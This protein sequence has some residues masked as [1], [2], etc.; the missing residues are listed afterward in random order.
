MQALAA[1]NKES[2]M[3]RLRQLSFAGFAAALLV[4]ACSDDAIVYPNRNLRAAAGESSDAG[5]AGEATGG[6]PS[7]GAA[8]GGG[9]GAKAGG[10]GAP[11]GDAGDGEVG[12]GAPTGPVCGDGKIEPPEQCDDGNAISGDGCSANCESSCEKCEKNVCPLWDISE[13][14]EVTSSAYEDCYRANGKITQGPAGGYTRAEVCRELLDCIHQEDCGQPTGVIV[15]VESCWCDKDWTGKVAGASPGQQC[16]ISPDPSNPQDPTKFIPGKCASLFQDASEGDRLSDVIAQLQAPR[17]AEGQALRLVKSC[18]ARACAEECVPAYFG[19]EGIA[20]ITADLDLTPN[21]AGE[22]PLGDLVA[23]AQRNAT[24]T[25]FALASGLV[26]QDAPGLTFAATPNRDADAAG[27]VL[28]SEAAAVNWGLSGLFGNRSA[29]VLSETDLYKVT[30]TGQQV[31]D[32]LTQQFGQNWMLR[33]SGLTYTYDASLPPAS[34][35]IDVRKDGASISKTGT[36]TVA[37][38]D[39]LAGRNGHSPIDALASG[40]NVT[41]VLNVSLPALLGEYLKQL[42]QPVAPPELN[43]ITRL[44]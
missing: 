24:G 39:F 42:P 38:S 13:G 15:R 5:E 41:K 1:K 43:R 18:D 2:R 11:L 22:S 16:V 12:G 10:G 3:M 14:D 44:N 30:L 9:G 36:Y 23:D 33:V 28:W 35:I 4:A 26:V 29:S 34:R 7:G 17:R 32:A 37:V 21:A 6:A 19:R 31:Y 25:D 27:R 8:T 20:T 40:T